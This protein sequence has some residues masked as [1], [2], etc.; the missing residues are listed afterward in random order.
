MKKKS[1]KFQL[2]DMLENTSKPQN[3]QCHQKQRKV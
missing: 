3:Y 2:T 1:D